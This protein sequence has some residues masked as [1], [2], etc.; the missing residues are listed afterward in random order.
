MMNSKILLI[1]T[2]FLALTFISNSQVLDKEW[3]VNERQDQLM[4]DINEAQKKKDLT[5]REAKGLRS[6]L[7]DVTRTEAK[8]KENNN[9][10]IPDG[11]K[12]KL[13][14]MLNDVSVRI[15]QPSLEKRV[16]EAKKESAEEKKAANEEAK[17]DKKAE[18]KDSK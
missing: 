12:A 17:K 10:K 3:T 6:D 5:A 16:A 9:D 8:I 1:A 7:A 14:S 18:K 2:A 4:K 13:E 11:D 15:K